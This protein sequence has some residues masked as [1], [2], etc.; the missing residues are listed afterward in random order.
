MRVRMETQKDGADCKENKT[1]EQQRV[2][3]GEV[4]GS[5]ITLCLFDSQQGLAYTARIRV[6]LSND[7]RIPISVVKL[8]VEDHLGGEHEALAVE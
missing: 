8:L 6:I 1:M 2:G 3:A 5:G 7:R 4:D